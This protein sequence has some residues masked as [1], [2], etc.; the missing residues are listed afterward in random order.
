MGRAP[1][2]W[3]PDRW[4]PGWAATLELKDSSRWAESGGGQP[5]LTPIFC[6]GP[7]PGR[8]FLLGAGTCTSLS[9]REYLHVFAAG[10][11]AARALLTKGLLIVPVTLAHVAE[12]LATA[13]ANG[14]PY[15]SAA[16]CGPVALA[17]RALIARFAEALAA[18]AF[19][20]IWETV[21]PSESPR[22]PWI[23]DLVFQSPGPDPGPAPG[24]C[25]LVCPHHT[26]CQTPHSGNSPM[27][28]QILPL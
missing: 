20:T 11:W 25:L 22:P 1:G 16:I 18:A 2:T 26:L 3:K 6:L 17:G 12:A 21:G 4:G 9:W 13:T 28:P 23:P 8:G 14:P 27:P 15:V 10:R 24:V 5:T 7:Q 19:P